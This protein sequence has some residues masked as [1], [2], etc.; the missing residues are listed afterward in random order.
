L[1]KRRIIIALALMATIAGLVLALTDPAGIFSLNS[2]AH[3]GN[4]TPDGDTSPPTGTW[5]SPGKV[6]VNNYTPGK[7]AQYEIQIHNGNN[8][9]ATF[10]VDY[11]VPDYVAEGFSRPT[12]DTRD[13]VWI[14]A[15]RPVIAPGETYTVTIRLGMPSTAA[16]PGDQWEFWIG[17]IDQSQTGNVQTELCTRWLVTMG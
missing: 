6:F 2:T 12:S 14:S 5:I 10:S 11:R 16:P 15:K 3:N 13:W 4:S 7:S 17:V 1:K 9:S 8:A